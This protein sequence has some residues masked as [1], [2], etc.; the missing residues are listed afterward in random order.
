MHRII[1]NDY[2][3]FFITAGETERSTS[4]TERKDLSP[5]K[6]FTRAIT[7][8]LHV[9]GYALKQWFL[10]ARLLIGLDFSISKLEL[11]IHIIASLPPL[12]HLHGIMQTPL[13]LANI[14]GAFLSRYTY[15][16][17]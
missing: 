7:L 5:G 12:L 14:K 16:H 8:K 4:E 2:T 13:R 6:W 9:H 10:Y 15:T 3:S 11:I 17:I 1:G